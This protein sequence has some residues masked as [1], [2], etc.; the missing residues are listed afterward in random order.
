MV[1]L[2]S[3]APS[4]IMEPKTKSRHSSKS[5]AASQ[6][7]SNS[8]LVNIASAIPGETPALTGVSATAGEESEA[9]PA[10][11]AQA[12]PEAPAKGREKKSSSRSKSKTAAK[13][14]E[15]SAVVV[16]TEEKA[17][18]AKERAAKALE[19]TPGFASREDAVSWLR[20]T[21]DG[22]PAVENL[23]AAYEQEVNAGLS[24]EADKLVDHTASMRRQ[25]ARSEFQLFP[26]TWP[27]FK[28]SEHELPGLLVAIAF[29]CLGAPLCYNTMKVLASL[30]PASTKRQYKQA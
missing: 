8:S 18:T 14:A 9:A 5:S 30:R 24:S 23:T 21:L 25:L 20:T 10:V 29:L 22:D 16:P 27:G 7:A 19:S 17:L 3:S 28:P 4:P 12:V 11:P 6:S 2:L 15:K 13:V 26:E 1:A